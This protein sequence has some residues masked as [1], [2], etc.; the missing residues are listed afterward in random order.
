[1]RT[2]SPEYNFQRL[3][4]R[5]WE[6]PGGELGPAVH[7]IPERFTNKQFYSVGDQEQRDHLFHVVL[8]LVHDLVESQQAPEILETLVD[9]HTRPIDLQASFRIK[10][11]IT[12]KGRW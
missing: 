9:F 4:V 5:A 1:M 6:L 3:L 10:S 12:H 8:G 2:K 11:V 7:L